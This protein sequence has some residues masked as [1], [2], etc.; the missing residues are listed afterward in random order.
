M[1]ESISP[2]EVWI[3]EVMI[4]QTQLK[5]VIPCW[6]K[7]MKTFPDL[8]SLVEA[9]EQEFLLLWQ[10]LGYYSR[11]KRKHQSSITLV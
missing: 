2:Y 3:A 8:A 1:A 4:Q 10:G 6:D 11:A 5:V 9:D 7:W